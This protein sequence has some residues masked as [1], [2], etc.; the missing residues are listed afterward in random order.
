LAWVGYRDRKDLRDAGA[1]HEKAQLDANVAAQHEADFQKMI[2]QT[3]AQIAQLTATIATRERVVIQ[4]QATD[5]AL[6]PD[7]L[8]ARIMT[9]APGGTVTPNPTG[10]QV[11]QPE[12][13]QIVA[14]LDLVEP[15][16]ADVT[17][18]K[19]VSV[20]KDTQITGLQQSLKDTQTELGDTG[21]VPDKRG[22]LKCQGGLCQADIKVARDDEARKHRKIELILTVL[23]Y[24]LGR[25]KL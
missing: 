20:A 12:A 15:L 21:Y 2:Q 1:A 14:Q 6:P 8:A 25:G 11:D 13:Q 18:L 16:K 5:K 3:Q 9:L 24:V 17:D 4:Q 19:A 22:A 7:Q 23:G 10:Y